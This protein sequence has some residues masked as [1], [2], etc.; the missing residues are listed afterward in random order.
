[1]YRWNTTKE[2]R[3]VIIRSRHEVYRKHFARSLVSLVSL[4]I[5]IFRRPFIAKKKRRK[6]PNN[7]T[8]DPDA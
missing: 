2:N 6:I 5:T 7:T 1:M 4:Y 8:H 3:E